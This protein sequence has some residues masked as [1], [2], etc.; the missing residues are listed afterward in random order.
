MGVTVTLFPVSV[1]RRVV[2]EPVRYGVV[3]CAGI[4]ETHAA[5][6]RAADDAR[7]VACADVDE[8]AATAF[9]DQHD[10][11]AAY[12]DATE[13]VTDGDVDAVSVCTPSGTHADV[14]VELAEVGADV[15]CEKPLDVYADRMD[16][17]IEACDA[18]G[19]TLGGVFQK[20][21]A[22]ASRLAKEAIEA[23]DLS[24]L[25]LGDTMVKWFRSQEYY[26][27]GDWRGTRDMDGGCL[28]NQAIHNI[29]RLQWLM[30]GVEE[31]QAAT[32]TL[33][34]DLECEDTAALTLRFE[35]GAVG[36]IEATTAVK[37]GADRTEINGTNGTIVFEGN[38]VTKFVVGDGEEDPYHAPTTD[39]EV[40][41]DDFEWPD[42]HV[43]AV[44]DF[45]DAVREGREPAVPGR[46][47]RKAVDVILAA[48]ES[49]ET[50]RAV[51]PGDV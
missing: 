20:R 37:G 15:L 28:M 43:A 2:T 40:N 48:Y 6:V 41:L 18:A 10:V 25:V 47:A 35:N 39:R 3:G 9:A 32:E 27:S 22:P 33:A 26:D 51:R 16:E 8:G 11:P 30:G 7:L 36:T 31:V 44:E 14:V 29:D 46:E 50:G 19:V 13:M 21:F 42:G 12:T 49:S 4:G 23:G 45:V 5:A 24:D 34:R 17:M 38:D 1:L